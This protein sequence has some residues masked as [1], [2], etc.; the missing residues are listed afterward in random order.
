MHI[1]SL[2]L[3]TAPGSSGA[4]NGAYRRSTSVGAEGS[5]SLDQIERPRV[6]SFGVDEDSYRPWGAIPPEVEPALGRLAST[7]SGAR[8]SDDFDAC[9]H[10]YTDHDRAYLRRVPPLEMTNSDIGK[11]AHCLT[12]TIGA[13]QDIA[14]FVPAMVRAQL[15]GV[16]LEDALVMKQLGRIPARDWTAERRDA[17]RAV[18]GA[19]F[20]SRPADGVDLDE[21]GYRIWIL[22]MLDRPSHTEPVERPIPGWDR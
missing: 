11:I 8:L 19:Y 18:Y 6:N 15:R 21:P 12:S 17:L 5:R 9:P 3:M 1:I 13:P 10:C 2:C 7:F 4:R 20:A 16:P 22:E 14:Y